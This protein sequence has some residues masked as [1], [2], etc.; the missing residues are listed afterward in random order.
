VVASPL[1]RASL[2]AAA[3]VPSIA[4]ACAMP[5]T[6]SPILYIVLW[7][8]RS[9]GGDGAGESASRTARRTVLSLR[10]A[11]PR[12]PHRLA[13]TGPPRATPNRSV[14]VPP[15]PRQPSPIDPFWP[16]FLLLG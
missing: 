5:D 1:A 4:A 2:R 13:M 7:C 16:D 9:T 10:R 12:W 6:S 14:S 8:L 11:R 15:R 3:N